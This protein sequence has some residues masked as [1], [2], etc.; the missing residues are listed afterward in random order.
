[1]R[2]VKSKNYYEQMLGR[3]TRTLNY[4]DLKRVSPSA[5]TNKTHFVV[6]D[7]IGVCKSQKTDARPLEKKKTV[8]MKDLLA[9]VLMGSEEEAVY[10]SLASRL[11]RLEKELDRSDKEQFKKLAN[12]LSLTQVVKQ[13]LT[14]HDPDEIESRARQKFNLPEGQQPNEQQTK[15]AKDDLIKVVR[16]SFN[17]ELNNFIE[18]SRQALEQIIDRTNI[19]KVTYAGWDAA[20]ADQT[21]IIV[22]E[23]KAYIEANKNEITALKILYNEPHN[24]KNITYQMI[25]DLFEHM[26]RNKPNLAPMRVYE[27]YAELDG[28]K[29]GS[30][31]TELTAIVALIRRVCGVDS[32]I[33]EYSH[34]VNKNFQDWVFNKHAGNKMKFTKEQVEW[35]HMIKDHISTSFHLDRDDLDL[36]PFDKRG[37]LAG[38]Y[39]LFGDV[40]DTIILEMNEA[41][42]A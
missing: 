11:A 6:I 15:A 8:P 17:G 19:D 34:K 36:S 3:G 7:A 21:K 23:F 41:L 9:Q 27:A 24:R 35:L 16:S 14:A 29:N 31:K 10:S 33:T 22:E 2:D 5:T 13:L 39:N 38:M 4:E 37:G 1:M 25:R 28:V 20:K 32:K 42:V 12:G 26:K 18:K 40:M 30:P